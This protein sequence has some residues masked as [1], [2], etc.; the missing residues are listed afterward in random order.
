MIDGWFS[1]LIISLIVALGG[2]AALLV[3]SYRGES[4]QHAEEPHLLPWHRDRHRRARSTSVLHKGRMSHIPTSA[5][6]E[7]ASA[8][9]RELL[10]GV[11]TQCGMVPN[12]SER[13]RIRALNDGAICRLGKIF[14][15]DVLID[16]I[17]AAQ[18]RRTR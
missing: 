6:I 3:Q 4:L 11:K 9:G 14:K 17:R 10:E 5:A 1:V 16:R 8:A 18:E 15:Q 12:P 7:D 2:L 13:L